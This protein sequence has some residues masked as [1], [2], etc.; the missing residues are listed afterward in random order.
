MTFELFGDI[1]RKWA[2]EMWPRELHVAVE[3]CLA[4]GLPI[5]D[6]APGTTA[7]AVLLRVAERSKPAVAELLHKAAE[8]PAS[9]LARWCASS[10]SA[11]LSLA[12]IL[13][14]PLK[15][16]RSPSASCSLPPPT[17]FGSHAA[18]RG[19]R[20]RDRTVKS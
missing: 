10:S 3:R 11:V 6:L 5:N 9:M 4:R 18:K 13:K 1:M 8:T 17:L 15:L 2:T 20:D 19:F 12:L 14:P 7:K 16:P